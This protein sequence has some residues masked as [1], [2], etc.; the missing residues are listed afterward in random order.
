MDGKTVTRSGR[1]KDVVGRLAEIA[2]KGVSEGTKIC[3]V[4]TIGK[5]TPTTAEGQRHD[6][7]RRAFLAQVSLDDIPFFRAI[8]T[9]CDAVDWSKTPALRPITSTRAPS[10]RRPMN[11]SQER[12]VR[13]ILSTKP[14]D[15]VCLVQGPPGTGKTTVI[16]E[17]VQRI[18][19]GDPSRSIYLIAQSNVA[20]KNI[21]EKLADVGFFDFRLLVSHEFHF[22]W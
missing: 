12:A 20:V 1:V 6:I 4:N 22:D 14:S 17:S 3:S 16:A 5:D 2:V 8:W 11:A 7:V 13:T 18:R 19:S 9:S 21:A 15:R 10:L